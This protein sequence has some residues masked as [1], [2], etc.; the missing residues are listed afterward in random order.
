MVFLLFFGTNAHDRPNLQVQCSWIS[1]SDSNRSDLSYLLSSMHCIQ[2]FVRAS[3][4]E[5]SEF[6][7]QSMKAVWHLTPHPPVIPRHPA[8]Q[9]STFLGSEWPPL[10]VPS[11]LGENLPHKQRKFS[12]IGFSNI[13]VKSLK[14]GF[15]CYI[16]HLNSLAS[17]PSVV[18]RSYM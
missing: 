5:T 3:A 14:Y 16:P 13:H 18:A 4:D 2:D 7:T 10:I 12:F 15:S 6:S 11:W 8:R 17:W 9:Q 1:K